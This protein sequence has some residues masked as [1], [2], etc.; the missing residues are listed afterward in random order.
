[1]DAQIH[2]SKRQF[3]TSADETPSNFALSSAG[4]HNWRVWSSTSCASQRCLRH[5]RQLSREITPHHGADCRIQHGTTLVVS[6]ACM[7]LEKAGM[8]IA[9]SPRVLTV[10]ANMP[11]SAGITAEQCQASS[12][13]CA[14][15]CLTH[16]T[17]MELIDQYHQ[18]LR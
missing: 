3:S 12:E 13:A 2:T 8:C 5:L 4:R 1:V 15:A 7:G 11:L 10:R 16:G 9:C 17:V 6:C 14:S 18:T